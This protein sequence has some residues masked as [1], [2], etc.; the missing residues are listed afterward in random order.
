MA[1]DDPNA[2]DFTLT[3]DEYNNLVDAV[4][5]S[6]TAF[7]VVTL[8]GAGTAGVT[9]VGFQ[10]SAVGFLFQTIGGNENTKR[11]STDNT[12]QPEGYAGGSYGLATDDGFRFG[13]HA[14]MSSNSVNASSHYASTTHPI[15]VRYA[16]A[17]GN[18]TG[19][20]EADVASFDT[21]GF[22]LQVDSHAQTEPI[23]YVAFR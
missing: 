6:Q 4:L 5:A 19:L 15:V 21:D 1:F 7:G 2:G 13:T 16:D 22:T 14:G 11:S 10:P 18:Q 9:G 20:L 12:R 3:A 8:T 23:A 17:D